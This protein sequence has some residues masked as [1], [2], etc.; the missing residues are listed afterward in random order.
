MVRL[1]QGVGEHSPRNIYFGGIVDDEHKGIGNRC[2]EILK[3][4]KMWSTGRD[5]FS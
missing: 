1:L 3:Y 4:V 2:A 5:L